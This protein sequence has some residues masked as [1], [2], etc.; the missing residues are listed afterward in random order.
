[1]SEVLC[2]HGRPIYCLECIKDDEEE[3]K[4]IAEMASYI[5]RNVDPKLWQA[6]KVKA[7]TQQTTVKAVIEKLL[8]GWVK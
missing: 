5:L 3:S 7:V 8:A 1:M 2:C 4:E 6:V